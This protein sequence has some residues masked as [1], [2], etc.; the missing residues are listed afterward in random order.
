MLLARPGL[1]ARAGLK[2]PESPFWLMF[3]A[4]FIFFIGIILVYCS[5][6]L[7]HRATIVFWDGMSRVASFLIILWFS[8]FP[9]MGFDMVLAASVELAIAI[10]YFAGLPRVLGRSFMDILL[11]RG[12]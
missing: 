10:V 5:R 9:G 6:D 8:L 4:I 1:L 11:D 12:C 2:P 3:P 7:K